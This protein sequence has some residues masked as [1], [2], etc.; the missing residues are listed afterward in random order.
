[1]KEFTRLGLEYQ[2]QTYILTSPAKTVIQTWPFEAE[3]KHSI[4]FL[5]LY[6][7]GKS[8]RSDSDSEQ[9]AEV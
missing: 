9:E 1:M 5:N 6:K 8:R 7:N 2:L 3:Q 4:Y